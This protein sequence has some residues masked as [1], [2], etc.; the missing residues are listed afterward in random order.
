MYFQN[1][2]QPTSFLPCQ[3]APITSW[4]RSPPTPSS[5]ETSETS[6]PPSSTSTSLVIKN[7]RLHNLG[8]MCACCVW[9]ALYS[10][11]NYDARGDILWGNVYFKTFLFRGTK[12]I[13]GNGNVYKYLLPLTYYHRLITWWTCP[14][15]FSNSNMFT[16]Q[17]ITS[18]QTMCMTSSLFALCQHI[19]AVWTKTMCCIIDRMTYYSCSSQCLV[20]LA[21]QH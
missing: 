12:Y 18:H 20:S 7:G 5:P 6:G 13:G 4:G 14:P 11:I 19:M 16:P 2:S 9:H 10:S 17:H 15:H 8:L 3:R 1:C 21:S